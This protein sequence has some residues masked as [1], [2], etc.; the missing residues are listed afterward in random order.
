M[1][2]PWWLP[3]CL[4]NMQT[5]GYCNSPDSCRKLL[6]TE[7]HCTDSQNY[8]HRVCNCQAPYQNGCSGTN[9][10]ANCCSYTAESPIYVIGSPSCYCCCGC[11]AHDTPVAYGGL[12]A[13]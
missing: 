13:G 2:D 3:G 12:C 11:F 9:P 10:P 1:A 4:A 5:A 6:C 7:Q 8:W